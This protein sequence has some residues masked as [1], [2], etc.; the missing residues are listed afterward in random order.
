[1]PLTALAGVASLFVGLNVLQWTSASGTC[2][3]MPQSSNIGDRATC[4]FTMSVDADPHRIPSELP[5]TKCNCLDSRC[6]DAGDYRCQEVK[7]TF[8]VAYRAD[9]GGLVNKTLELT[10]SCVCIVY[11]SALAVFGGPRTTGGDPNKA[12]QF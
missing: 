10:T 11:K 2:T 9:G 1:M 7:S 8:Q 3:P 5:V 4:P 12:V 6:S